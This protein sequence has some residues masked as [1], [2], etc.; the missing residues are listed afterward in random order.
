MRETC[1]EM[2]N[3][4]RKAGLLMPVS[5]LPSEYGVGDFG[6]G[7]LEFI[8]YMKECGQIGRAHV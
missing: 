2:E 8:D 7:S 6:K 3:I 5:A 4:M 1:A